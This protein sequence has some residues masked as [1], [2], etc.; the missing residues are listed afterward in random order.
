ML[1]KK[2]LTGEE[3]QFILFS[4]MRKGPKKSLTKGMPL[5]RMDA[6]KEHFY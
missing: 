3:S 5:I 6:N 1:L 2:C 4:V